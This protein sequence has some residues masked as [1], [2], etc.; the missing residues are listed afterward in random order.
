MPSPFVMHYHYKVDSSTSGPPIRRI[1]SPSIRNAQVDN[2]MEDYGKWPFGNIGSENH[3]FYI[4][5]LEVHMPMSLSIKLLSHSL[6]HYCGVFY[7]LLVHIG[8]HNQMS[9]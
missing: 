8:T 9:S 3:A 2:N 1:L 6:S 5:V 7:Y 4:V